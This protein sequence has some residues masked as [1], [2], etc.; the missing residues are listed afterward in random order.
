M[1]PD[2]ITFNNMI[3]QCSHDGVSL[4]DFHMLYFLGSE[5]F[6]D[7]AVLHET[8]AYPIANSVLTMNL[9]FDEVCAELGGLCVGFCKGVILLFV[10]G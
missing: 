3:Y 9:S 7:G 8:S 10:A 2:L 5:S 1:R 4:H 6:R